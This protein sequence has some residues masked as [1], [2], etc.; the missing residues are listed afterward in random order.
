MGGECQERL[1]MGF[2]D[3]LETRV[4]PD[5][6]PLQRRQGGQRDDDERQAGRYL[7]DGEVLI[8]VRAIEAEDRVDLRRV[9]NAAEGRLRLVHPQQI[10]LALAICEVD[11]HPAAAE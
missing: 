1:G 3:Q 2:R 11:R 10:D 4:P 7:L 9:E 6:G 8:E 5:G